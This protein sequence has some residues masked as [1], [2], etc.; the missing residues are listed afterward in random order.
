MESGQHAI[1]HVCIEA[2]KACSCSKI[3][4]GLECEAGRG[5][6]ALQLHCIW[7]SSA[8]H[9]PS[10][11]DARLLRATAWHLMVVRVCR[12]YFRKRAGHMCSF[13]LSHAMSMLSVMLGMPLAMMT[14]AG[15]NGDVKMMVVRL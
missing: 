5:Y 2:C 1:M 9:V 7:H 15:C 8:V 14:H 3:T 12:T 11:A 6:R 13:A 4:A 10:P